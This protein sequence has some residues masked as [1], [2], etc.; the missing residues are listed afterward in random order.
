MEPVFRRAALLGRVLVVDDN[1][2]NQKVVVALLT[3]M[4]YETDVAA[5]GL[6]ALEALGERSYDVVLM[7]IY[8]PNMDGFEATEEIRRQETDSY[9]PIVA[10]TGSALEAD[11][12]RCFEVGM[13]DFIV[14][15]VQRDVLSATL[16]R[17][18]VS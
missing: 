14:K 10:L 18:T 11:R 2:I 6:E 3:K 17:L 7:D 12:E 4:H 13:D 9:T 15:P 5:D 16:L 8:M 1:L